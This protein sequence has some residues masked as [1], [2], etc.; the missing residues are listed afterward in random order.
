[1]DFVDI[2]FGTSSVFFVLGVGVGVG[3]GSGA[4]CFEFF[5]LKNVISIPT[6]DFCVKRVIWA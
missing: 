4:D 3:G 2:R 5:D 1:M 6:Q